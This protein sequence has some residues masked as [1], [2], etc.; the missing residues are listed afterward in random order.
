MLES[1]ALIVYLVAMVAS[2]TA[3]RGRAAANMSR[4]SLLAAQLL[5]W[6]S[7]ACLYALLKAQILQS[8]PLIF[9]LSVLTFIYIV[10]QSIRIQNQ[11]KLLEAGAIPDRSPD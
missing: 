6:F 7:F 4:K 10:I 8:T 1:V 9:S 3:L 11:S 5:M 2:V